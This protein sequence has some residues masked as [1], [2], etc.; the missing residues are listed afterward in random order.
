MVGALQAELTALLPSVRDPLTALPVSTDE[1][2]GW[3]S[4]LPLEAPAPAGR[5]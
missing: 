1:N 4:D 2:P 5:K 3:N